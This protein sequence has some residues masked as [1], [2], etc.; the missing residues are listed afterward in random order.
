MLR[1]LLDSRVAADP[2]RKIPLYINV[3]KSDNGYSFN[4][5]DILLV[6]MNNVNDLYRNSYD[7]NREND[8]ILLEHGWDKILSEFQEDDEIVN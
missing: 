2:G 4:C 1:I 6:G 5:Y 7:F 8:L 3:E